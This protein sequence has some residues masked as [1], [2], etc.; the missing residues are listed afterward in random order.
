MQQSEIEGLSEA[1]ATTFAKQPVR[2]IGTDK[3]TDALEIQTS[4]WI[5]YPERVFYLFVHL[6]G[7]TPI[8]QNL[9]T[10][11]LTAIPM[12]VGV[13]LTRAKTQSST[14]IFRLIRRGPR[15]SGAG[16]GCDLKRSAGLRG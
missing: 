16:R 7:C 10:H 5:I 13:I 1:L 4:V 14:G 2:V 6:F 8:I 15:A 9:I 12:A 11:T 3:E